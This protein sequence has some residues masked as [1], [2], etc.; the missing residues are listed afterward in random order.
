MQLDELRSAASTQ[1]VERVDGSLDPAMVKRVGT[2][3]S[4]SLVND[5]AYWVFNQEYDSGYDSAAYP[6]LGSSA[7]AVSKAAPD[8]MTI[9]GLASPQSDGYLTQFGDVSVLLDTNGDGV[10]DF[11]AI[12][13]ST[14]MYLGSNYTTT[15]YRFIGS[16]PVSTGLTATWGRT[17]GAWGVTLPWRAMGITGARHVMALEDE[18]GYLDWSPNSYGT[19]A[20]LAGVV[21]YTPPPAPAAQSVAGSVP[22]QTK[23]KRNKKVALPKSTNTGA[24]LRWSTRTPK[25]C[26]ISSGRVVLTGKKGSCKITATESGS[27]TRLS[28]SK[29]YTIKAK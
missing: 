9:V 13:P 20:Q 5:P 10:S 25:I 8:A 4:R 27:T 12:T 15:L 19:Y 26:K 16:T 7:L 1:G 29:S 24:K 21:G 2:P 22:K 23:A 17:S 3:T 6:E 18:D 28:L 14:Y 11:G